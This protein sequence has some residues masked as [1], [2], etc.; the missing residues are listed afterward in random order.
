[1]VAPEGANGL[2]KLTHEAMAVVPAARADVLSDIL[3][4][5]NPA[6][7][8]VFCATKREVESIAAASQAVLSRRE[9][10]ALHGDI[11]QRTRNRI[12][13]GFRSGQEGQVLVATDVA[14]RGLDISELD[15][16]VQLGVPREK[17]KDGTVDGDLYTH[18][19]GR[20][21]RAG[22]AGHAILLFDPEGGERGLLPE[23]ETAAGVTL[24]QVP[25]PSPSQAQEAAATTALASVEQISPEVLEPFLEAAW[26]VPDTKL[27]QRLA[28]AL[29][30]VAGY[31]AESA[32][33]PR[34]LLTSRQTDLTVRAVLLPGATLPAAPPKKHA[35]VAAAER[36]GSVSDDGGGDFE[37]I[38]DPNETSLTLETD[39]GAN[40]EEVPKHATR[41]NPSHVVAAVKA[42]LPGTKLGRVS[43]CKDGQSAVFDLP[44][45]RAV[46]LVEAPAVSGGLLGF[47]LPRTLPP[48]A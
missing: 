4:I 32:P 14:A 25:P 3:S 33:K 2:E 17:G 1:M 45:A 13:D 40:G 19:S 27:R 34:S 20:T 35:A 42:A 26:E 5:R 15:L 21:A 11:P 43:I 10:S 24:R 9:V 16:V 28:Q 46:K 8:L 38:V 39:L 30:L 41:L 29:A 12:L 31:T 36:G 37:I 18:R 48:M 44:T 47:S 22:R 23:L 7:T 6:R